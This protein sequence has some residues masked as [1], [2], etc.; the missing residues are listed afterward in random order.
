MW[1]FYI[2][3]FSVLILGGFKIGPYSIR[4]Y[5]VLIMMMYLLLTKTKVK[6]QISYKSMKVFLLYIVVTGLVLLFIGEFKDYDYFNR[7]LAFYFPCFVTVAAINRFIDTKQSLL[8]LMWFLVLLIF[9]N[10]IIT[11]LQFNGLMLGKVIAMALNTSMD[12][13]AN[14]LY[15]NDIDSSLLMGAGLPIGIF[16]FVFSNANYTAT[17]GILAL[18]LYD[19][20]NRNK[21]IQAFLLLVVGLCIYNCYMIQERT[22]FFGI[23]AASIFILNK[24]IDRKNLKIVFIFLLI[25]MLFIFLP[26]IWNAESLGRLVEFNSKEDTRNEIWSKCFTFISEN[27]LMGGPVSYSKLT[28]VAPHNYFLNAIITSGIIGGSIAIYLYISTTLKAAK[29]TISGKSHFIRTT[30]ASVCIYAFGCLF[31][32]A[33]IISG[34]TLFFV[35]YAILLKTVLINHESEN[36]MLHR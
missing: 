12:V 4:V 31:H 16:S 9:V 25:L 28:E 36:T 22:A 1:F 11:Q 6:F 35:L 14:I 33:S 17:F 20:Y 30:A 32:N 3:L 27:F 5:M 2:F 29:Y 13:Q 8:H 18:Y 26:S 15:D 23:I 10:C 19:Y 34:D 24:N 7:C 21:F